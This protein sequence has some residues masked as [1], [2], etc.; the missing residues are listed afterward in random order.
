MPRPLFEGGLINIGHCANWFHFD[1]V[2]STQDTARQL[3]SRGR[4]CGRAVVMADRQTGG[5]GRGGKSWTSL[6]GGLWMTVVLPL[7]PGFERRGLYP[8]A[9]G[10]AAVDAVDEI[11][12]CAPD[13][14]WPNDLLVGGAKLGGILC[15]TSG[16]HLLAGVGINVGVDLSAIPRVPGSMPP[17]NFAALT[18]EDLPDGHGTTK[19]LATA[20]VHHLFLWE[21]KIG[22]APDSII[23]AWSTRSS[24]M[25]RVVDVIEGGSTYWA[26]VCGLDPSGGLIVEDSTGS[27]RTLNSAEVSLRIPGGSE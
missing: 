22:C 7:H 16:S 26:V 6:P 19:R 1:D 14:K 20:L 4:S 23:D 12:G 18:G 3:L 10:I 8:L 11:A 21:P 17:A 9:V 25:G 27:T 13:L 24:M 5:R 2:V 15:E